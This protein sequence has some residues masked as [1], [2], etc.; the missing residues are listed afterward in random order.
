[1]SL[2]KDLSSSCLLTQSRKSSY[3][4]GPEFIIWSFGFVAWKETHRQLQTPCTT[5][6]CVMFGSWNMGGSKN[7]EQQRPKKSWGSDVF[8][9]TTGSSE[10]LLLLAVTEIGA[11]PK[12]TCFETHFFGEF[13]FLP[14]L[15]CT[16]CVCQVIYPRSFFFLFLARTLEIKVNCVFLFLF[17]F[18][19]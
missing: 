2:G 18:K 5:C 9:F 19:G 10:C 12:Y 1:M 16:T 6:P 17:L 8:T 14:L 4:K 13:F 3:P 7:Q 15:F 11:E